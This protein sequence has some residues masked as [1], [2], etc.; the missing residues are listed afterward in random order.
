MGHE[1]EALDRA[2][3]AA[4][5]GESEAPFMLPQK[6]T[7]GDIVLNWCQKN[8]LWP[9][10]FGLSCCFV[11]QATVFTGLYDIARFGAEVLRGSPRQ[12]DLL[13]VSGTVFKKAAP[14]V[15][16]IYEQMPR[17][18][19]VISMGSCANTG[20]MYDVYSVVQGVDQIIPVDVYVTGC[21]PRPEALM[22]GLIT[23]QDMISQKNRPLRPAFNLK[24]GHAG[25]RD[26]ILV[27]GDS[28]DRDTRGPGMAGIPAR[29]TSVTP[30]EF[31]DSRS[32]DMWAPPPP[33]F[34]FSKV[35]ESIRQALADRF[36]DLIVWHKTPVDMPTLTVTASHIV[37]I[38]DFLKHESPVRFERLEDLTAVD[39]SA[40]KV[41]PEHD[42]TVIYT[43]TSL[44]SLEYI[45]LHVPVSGQ[46]PE[47]PS[48][49][50]VWP[51]ANWYECEIWDMFGI[52][53]SNHPGLRRLI[54]PEEWSGHP[55]RKSEPQRA[56]DM[57]PYLAED[58]RRHEPE[59]AASLLKK[60][61]AAT[62]TKREF[63]LNIG[64]HHY[65]THGLVR[66][67]LEMYGE[68][69]VDMTADIGFHHR[70]V[71][72]IAEHQS[73]HQFIPYT[74]RLDYLSGAANNLTYLLAVEKLCDVKVPDRAQCV[75]VMLAEFYRI[76]NHLLWLGTMVQD[77]GMI[78]PV[79]HTFRER[80]QVMDIMET[81]TGARLHPAWLRIGGLAMDLPEG[82]DKLVN[83]F[84]RVFPERIEGYKRMISGNP[85]VRA[86]IKGIGNLSLEDAI[87]Y[88]ISG[89]NLRAC[90]STRD[91]RKVMPY[92]GYE[93]YEFDVPTRDNGDCLARYEVRFD[94]MLQSNRII[95]QCLQWMPSGRFKSKDYR[96][97]IPDK[98]ETLHDIES[99]IHHFINT[100]RGPK[101]PAG[102]AYAATEA[103]RGEQGFYIVSDGGNM[104]YRLHM[105]SPGYTSVQALPLMAVGHTLADF[106]A[107][108][109]SVDYIAPDLDR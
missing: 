96:Y 75:R 26:D 28:K 78:T 15:Q 2:I 29:G 49:T 71:E 74:D 83:D 79:F 101:V 47:L 99:L 66:F 3:Q 77:L 24:G 109:G 25:G 86:R 68:E 45:R 62:P 88:G 58:A 11:E 57:E 34:N 38:L 36:G 65:S 84:V 106:V 56:T 42:Y 100:T 63:V 94:E 44:S 18:K 23:L 61:H 51:S 69:I 95:A 54:M 35:H 30:P 48:V 7:L 59:D 5:N 80:E 6:A 105:R 4:V 53:F 67:I 43:L 72:K 40:R 97:C 20:G 102:E 70:G 46:E 55:L 19:W 89:A 50:R 32:N 85:I 60:S 14:M 13:V 87:D 1:K 10:F 64:P 81:I 17:P 76:S 107:I 90:G 21:P 82:W 39:E 104:P 31:A 22:H 27:P 73:W 93:Q 9:L 91:L 16:R 98:R 52:R 8:S 103:P 12:A 37:E 92:S 108:M 33:V 41:R